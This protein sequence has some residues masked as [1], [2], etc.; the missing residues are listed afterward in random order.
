MENDA[1]GVRK[2]IVGSELKD[3]VYELNFEESVNFNFADMQ[4]G[5]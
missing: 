4:L 1:A 3:E 2:F 5:Q